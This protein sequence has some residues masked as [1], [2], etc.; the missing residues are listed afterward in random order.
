MDIKSALLKEHSRK[1]ALKISNYIGKDPKKF[2]ILAD[3]FLGN[4]Y[5]LAQRAAYSINFCGTNHPNLITPLIPKM[6][7]KLEDKNVHDAVKRNSLRLFQFISIPKKYHGKVVQTSF[8]LLQDY[9]Q[10]IA[11]RVFAMTT[12]ANLC[13]LYPELSNELL[14]IIQK[15]LSQNPKPAYISRAKKALKI[16]QKHRNSNP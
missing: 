2:K 3:F 12:I 1:Q 8:K 14:P 13:P 11:I 5:R 6:L 7:L 16:I 4:E 9:S 10:P 15:E